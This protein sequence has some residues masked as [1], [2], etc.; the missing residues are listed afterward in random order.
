[1]SHL[2]DSKKRDFWQ[3]KN[4]FVKSGRFRSLFV[5]FYRTFG[6]FFIFYY[7]L[8]LHLVTKLLYRY[9][10]SIKQEFSN[11]GKKVFFTAQDRQWKK[12]TDYKR[13]Q[14]IYDDSFFS[15]VISELKRKHYTPIGIYHIELNP[16][17]GLLTLVEKII[18][19][20]TLQIPL[21]AY[22][23]IKAY[24]EEAEAIKHFRK[25]FDIIKNDEKFYNLCSF[26]GN[27]YHRKILSELEIYFTILFPNAVKNIVTAR[28]MFENERPFGIILINEH[29]WWERSVII[30]AKSESVPTL[31]IQHGE[32]V[33]NNKNYSYSPGE[34][35][36]NGRIE[37][38]CC[39]IPDKL[40]V[41][42]QYYKELITKNNSYPENTIAITGH[43]EY[44]K[45][46]FLM[47]EYP[48]TQLLHK[49]YRVD[50]NKKVILWTTQFHG[51][52][53]DENIAAIDCFFRTIR[54]IPDCVLIIKPHPLDG[55]RY[56]KI[57]KRYMGRYGIECIITPKNSDT[58]EQIWMC[59]ILVTKSSTTALE[60]IGFDKPLII[61]NLSG[62][63][64]EV[65]YVVS[66]VALG[67]NS[68]DTFRPAIEKLLASDSEL[69]K[70]RP[71]YLIKYMHT[72]DGNASVRVVDV[73]NQMVVEQRRNQ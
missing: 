10:L 36:G 42:G 43:P 8:G 46:P 1:V 72:M 56:E 70:N 62:T 47:S 38:P 48:D 40:A 4:L 32:I 16:V 19:W 2:I 67:V 57:L 18:R 27:N 28:S 63:P 33:S 49:K 51:F 13:K 26:Q 69:A 66:G 29:F 34:I 11:E 37:S 55:S 60:A 21:N 50:N 58:S 73:F 3:N 54:Q 9:S 25:M 65:N 20:D 30:S 31:A 7:N 6:L 52:S 39:P 24:K 15:P 41:F 22:W 14:N 71:D 5:W 17:S 44:D 59:D 12:S 68:C 45:I 35:C 53:D 61:L 64:D 23:S